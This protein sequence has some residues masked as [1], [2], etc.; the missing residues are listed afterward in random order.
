MASKALRH[1]IVVIRLLEV[2]V[3]ASMMFKTIWVAL[4]SVLAA[5][6]PVLHCVVT[7][8]LESS[9]DLGPPLAHLCNHLLNK[10][11]FFRGDRVMIQRRLEVLMVAFA[12]LL[13]RA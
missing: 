4:A 3:I 12:T 2:H 6:P 11:S 5:I 13:G 8:T 9:C 7:S 1:R 10:V